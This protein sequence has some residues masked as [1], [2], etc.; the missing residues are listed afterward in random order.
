MAEN[1][2]PWSTHCG[3]CSPSSWL[4]AWNLPRAN[5]SASGSRSK[6][7]NWP[8]PPSSRATAVAC[9][10]NP[11]VASTYVPPARTFRYRIAS[12]KRTGT[13]RSL[14]GTM[15]SPWGVQKLKPKTRQC[16]LVVRGQRIGFHGLLELVV[17]GHFEV[18]LLPKNHCISRQLCCCPQ[19]LGQQDPALCI[20]FRHLPVVID[21]VQEL[22]SGRIHAGYLRHLLLNFL[23]LRQGVNLGPSSILAGDVKLRS[24]TLVDQALELRRQLEPAF[25]V[26]AGWVIA[27]KHPVA[28]SSLPFTYV[29][30]PGVGLDTSLEAGF[31]V[32]IAFALKHVTKAVL[33]AQNRF[34]VSTLDHFCPHLRSAERAVKG[35]IPANPSERGGF[36]G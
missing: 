20:H 26:H 13:C 29:R 27:T 34:F 8:A 24:V 30:S 7:M 21:P 19:D 15:C 32:L 3:I 36:M 9:P 25:F 18:C 14:L 28:F 22:L 5:S 16:L 2:S 10:P 11:R 1:G 6:P 35:E 4:S 33:F 12:C 17:V 23:P 31:P